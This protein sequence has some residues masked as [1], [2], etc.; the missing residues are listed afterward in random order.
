M[1]C[2]SLEL[3]IYSVGDLT[4]SIHGSKHGGGTALFGFSIIQ[5][6]IT[7]LFGGVAIPFKAEV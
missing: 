5:S 6:I 1:V 2:C 7:H 3:L 4:I